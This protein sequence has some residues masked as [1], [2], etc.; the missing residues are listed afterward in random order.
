MVL[1]NPSSNESEAAAESSRRQTAGD[2]LPLNKFS[3][4]LTI[5]LVLGLPVVKGAACQGQDLH[6]GEFR[7]KRP[8]G[9]RP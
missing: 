4:W 7:Q 3:A 9:S 8:G 5:G 2:I 6:H 1:P